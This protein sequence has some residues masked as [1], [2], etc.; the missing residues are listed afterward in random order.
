MLYGRTHYFLPTL[1]KHPVCHVAAD[2]MSNTEPTADELLLL[3]HIHLLFIPVP[4][5]I[6]E[7]KVEPFRNID[8]L[9]LNFIHAW[10]AIR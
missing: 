6:V 7:L 1:G 5:V 10:A 4:Y 8:C 9:T 2:L 3:S